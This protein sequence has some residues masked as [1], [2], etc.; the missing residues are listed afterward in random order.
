MISWCIFHVSRIAKKV[1]TFPHIS[2]RS[3]H[4]AE[5]RVRLSSI[6]TAIADDFQKFF[7]TNE[8]HITDRISY[9]LEIGFSLKVKI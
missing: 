7:S 8:T 1:L 4:R 2:T 3:N 5:K 9:Q 6:L